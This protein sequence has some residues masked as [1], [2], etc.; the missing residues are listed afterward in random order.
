MVSRDLRHNLIKRIAI[1]NLLGFAA[2]LVGTWIWSIIFGS[3]SAPWSF[4]SEYLSVGQTRNLDVYVAFGRAG[5]DIPYRTHSRFGPIRIK[6]GPVFAQYI[7]PMGIVLPV[8]LAY[9]GFVAVGAFLQSSRRSRR[10]AGGQ[11]PTC[12]YELAESAEHVCPECGT[13]SRGRRAHLAWYLLA[14]KTLVFGAVSLLTLAF[15]VPAIL[16]VRLLSGR[17]MTMIELVYLMKTGGIQYAILLAVF[18]LSYGFVGIPL[19]L[20]KPAMQ[21]FCRLALVVVA[22]TLLVWVAL[23]FMI[24]TPGWGI[25]FVILDVLIVWAACLSLYFRMPDE[26]PRSTALRHERAASGKAQPPDKHS[27]PKD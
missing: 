1:Y 27:L 13:D 8:V 15:H 19:L 11:C 25:T 2:L 6:R 22:K 20:R 18:S 23:T 5:E 26:L 24:R 3:V 14:D 4:Q 17:Y 16:L 21:L 10:I 9:P 12:G 7:I